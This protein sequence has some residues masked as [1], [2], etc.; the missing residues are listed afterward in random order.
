MQISDSTVTAE[1]SKSIAVVVVAISLVASVA[2][3]AADYKLV[4]HPSVAAS[5]LSRATVSSMFLKKTARWPDGTPVAAVDQARGSQVRQ[6]FSREVLEKSVEMLDA[7]WQKQVF[8]GRATP[9][10]TRTNDADVI[11]YVRSVPGAIG[12]VSAGAN[13]SGVKEVR[14][15]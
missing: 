10:L 13:T 7:F 3:A 11:A 9:P 14:L 15:E 12:Y 8:T 1:R 6:A 2:A 5:T 4:V